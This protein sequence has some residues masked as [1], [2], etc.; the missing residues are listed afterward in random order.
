[1]VADQAIVPLAYT[2]GG[3]VLLSI[4]ELFIGPTVYAAASKAAPKALLGVTMGAVAF[5]YSLASL[6]SGVISQMMTVGE[7]DDSLAIYMRGFLVLAIGALCIAVVIT[8]KSKEVV[9]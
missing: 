9:A 8:P 7:G 5:G 2:L 1:M 6:L 4:G 3:M